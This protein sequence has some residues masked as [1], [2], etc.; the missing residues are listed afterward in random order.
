MFFR[1][2][3]NDLKLRFVLQPDERQAF[4]MHVLQL[5]IVD[6]GEQG[7]LFEPR[8]GM[9]ERF[10]IAN[11]IER[12]GTARFLQSLVL[13]R[14]V[15][16]SRAH[17]LFPCLDALSVPL[18]GQLGC[19]ELVEGFLAL[20]RGG[21]GAIGVFDPINERVQS[22]DMTAQFPAPVAAMEH[23]C[24]V[25][26]L[27]T[28]QTD[29]G[30]IL[31]SLNYSVLQWKQSVATVQGSGDLVDHVRLHMLPE[32]CKLAIWMVLHKQGW[33]PARRATLSFIAPGDE[34]LY[35]QNHAT[36]KWYYIVLAQID[37]TFDRLASLPDRL[38]MVKHKMPASYY[39]ALCL[40]KDNG[41]LLALLDAADDA[42]PTADAFTPFCGDDDAP[43]PDENDEPAPPPLPLPPCAAT[44]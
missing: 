16:V 11:F 37:D 20:E 24:S 36:A 34:K 38:P 27:H 17:V 39:K 44:S 19:P 5:R 25:G 1:V 40:C 15:A 41:Q 43:D 42:R 14:D 32:H 8:R 35:I 29:F 10:D 30:E 18:R 3:Q 33:R 22:L 26:V 31:L 28:G 21:H 6:H 7:A 4:V 12:V 23:L 13:W 2:L 9:F